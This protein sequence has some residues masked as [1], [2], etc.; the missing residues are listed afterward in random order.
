[1]QIL[2]LGYLGVNAESLSD[3]EDYG[4]KLLGLQAVDKS[5]KTTAFRM[6]DRRQRL[7]VEENG[8]S[9]LQYFGWE[10]LDS[11]ALQSIA[12]KVEAAG[13]TVHHD[14]GVLAQQ[15]FVREL[16]WFLD[17]GGNRIELFYGAEIASEAFSPGRDIGGFRTGVHGLGHAVLTCKSLEDLLPFYTKILGFGISD[18]VL[19]PFKA[20]FLHVNPRHHSL[21]LVETGEKGVHHIMMELMQFDDVGHAYDLAD[22]R[23]EE[24]GVTLGRHTNDY[25]TSFYTYSP[26]KFMVEYGWGGKE[27]DPRNCQPFELVDGPSI[28]GHNRS[29]L[30][31]EANAIAREQQK[32]NAEIGLRQPMQV[33]PGNHFEMPTNCEWW[34]SFLRSKK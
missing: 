13:I 20:Y 19:Q 6:D 26:S 14:N 23:D 22:H 33:L 30:S 15:R 3:W 27:V 17:P 28:W 18:Y 10:V 25:M 12:A 7:Y 4:T 11:A 31:D 1:M 32:R 16:V 21:A 2:S 8:K 9:S 5:T 34:E 24:I 29:W